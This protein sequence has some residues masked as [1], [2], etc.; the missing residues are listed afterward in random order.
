MPAPKYSIA[1]LNVNAPRRSMARLHLPFHF[2]LGLAL[3]AIFWFAA[4]THLGVLGEHSFFP[5][6][7]GYIFTVD[8]LVARRTGASLLMRAPR[9]FVLLFFL[10]APIWWVFEGLNDFVL[11]WHYLIPAD[12]SVAQMIVESTIA[13][14]TVI[15]AVFETTE[16]ILSF[17]F[18]EHW[19]GASHF[20]LSP[21]LLW[22][23]MFMG[24]FGFAAL[25]LAPRYA[26]PLT[27]VWLALIIDPLNHLR[28]RASL[29]AQL[30][31]GDYRTLIGLASGVLI[32]GFFWEMWNYCSFPKWY[33]TVPFFGWLHVF[34]MPLLG[35]L[36]YIPFAWELYAL[37]QWVWGMRQRPVRFLALTNCQ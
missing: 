33:Y 15:P 37:S 8:G 12:Y 29:I 17:D 10:S 35:Y 28:G 13:F 34:E 6:W 20:D 19:R 3:V 23:M 4:W 11:N 26:F 31:R 14:S 22:S 9:D 2:F 21:R 36:G 27:W 16:L 30:A 7:L 25:V 32:C 5:L 1:E 18:I 24:A